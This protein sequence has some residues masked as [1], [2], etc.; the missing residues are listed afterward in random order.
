MADHPG[1][2]RFGFHGSAELP[3]TIVRAAGRRAGEVELSQ[4]AVA[5]PFRGLRAGELD[6]MVVKFRL[7]EPDL[8]H[9]AV[10]GTDA[11]AAILG[12]GHPL[13][14]RDSV[15]IEELAAFGSFHRPG[16][17]PDYVWDEVVPPVT[18]GG[19][20]VHRRHRLTTT[21]E[22]LDLVANAGAVHISLLSLAD[23]APPAVRVVPIHDLPPAP[24]AVAWVAAR[25]TRRVRDFVD[26]A[27]AAL[28]VR[29]S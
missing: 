24:V 10:L 15:S 7:D 5:D 18:P 8:A 11:R 29:A 3:S 12:A 22:M 6:L 20:T 17:M 19:R 2:L 16:S 13:A 27:E 9:S 1:P 26:A 21:A 25:T 4:Y 23:I 28:A 14:G